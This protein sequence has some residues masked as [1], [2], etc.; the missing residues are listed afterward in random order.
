MSNQPVNSP[1]DVRNAIAQAEKTGRQDILLRI[2]TKDDQNSIRGAPAPGSA[3][4][5]LGPHPKLDP[6]ALNARESWK[7]HWPTAAS[8]I[9]RN[10][11]EIADLEVLE[12]RGPS[13]SLRR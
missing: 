10:R 12:H 9:E 6:F 11:D 7:W 5:A 1:S 2:K 13:R 8:D 4:V 3:A